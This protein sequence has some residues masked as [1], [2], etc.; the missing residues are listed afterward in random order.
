[1]NDFDKTEG[2]QSCRAMREENRALRLRLEELE[3][4]DA[5]RASMDEAYHALV[6]HSLQGLV[7]FQDGRAVFANQAMAA[8][9]GY[10]VDEILAMSPEAIREFVHP[11]DRE[12]VW[13]RSRKRLAG[14][15]APERYEMRGVRKDGGICWLEIHAS[16]IHFRDRPAI[17]AAYVDITERKRGGQRMETLAHAALGLVGMPT[18]ADVF[19]F[20]AEKVLALIGEGIVSVHS[21]EGNTLT[22]RKVMGAKGHVLK[23]A[24]RLL[25]GHVIGLPID[26][27]HEEARTKL[28][29]GRLNKVEGGL[30]E[31]FFHTVPQTVC[32][33]LERAIGGTGQYSVGLRQ[34]GRL[35]GNVT[36]L[37]Q[38]GTEVDDW[39]IEV[40]V[41]QASIVLER[42]EA[43]EA[44]RRSEVRLTRVI[45]GTDDATWEWPDLSKEETWWSPR[46]FELLGYRPNAF[47]PTTSRF[48]EMMHPDDRVLHAARMRS[49][50]ESDKPFEGEYRLRH[51][52]GTYHWFHA[53]GR[54]FRDETGRPICMSGSVRDVSREKL[55]ERELESAHHFLQTVLNSFPGNVVVLD[56]QGVIV[57]ANSS[58]VSFGQANGLACK[59]LEEGVNYLE[60]TRSAK[61]QWSEGAREVCEAIEAI[62]R[63]EQT[64][65]HREYPCHS[66][67]KQRWFDMQTR[68]FS[69]AGRRW[70]VVAHIDV[71]ERKES[72]LNRELSLSVL[73]ILNRA[74]NRTEIVRDILKL[75]KAHHGFTAVAIRLC[76]GDDYPYFVQNGF[77]DDFVR[78][79][80]PLCA[81][82][83][84]GDLVR[85]DQGRPLLECM[86]GNVIQGRVDPSQSFFTKGGSFW[87]NGTTELL[88]T[89]R[90][91]DRQAR[92]RN[93][94]N[95]EGYE[96]V[97]LIPLRSGDQVIGLLQMNDLRPGRFTEERVRFFEGVG[98]SIGIAISRR[99][100]DEALRA[101]EE[102]Y[103][104]LV[105]N[106]NDVIFTVNVEGIITYLSPPMR[107]LTGYAPKELV[108]RPFREIVHSE[109][110]PGLDRSFRDVLANRLELSEFRYHAKDGSLRWA[111]TSSRPILRN[112][113]AMGIRGALID[114][115]ERKLME[116]TLAERNRLLVEINALSIELASL[117]VEADVQA[118]AAEYLMRMAGVAAAWF[119]EY[120]PDRK[121][122][123]V[124]HVK[125]ESGLL[126]KAAQLLGR[127]PEGIPSPVSDEMYSE[128]I[129]APVGRRKTL[130]EMSF[131]SIPRLVGSAVQALLGA[132]RF[133]GLAHVIEGKLFGTS[134]LAMKADRPDPPT[135]LLESIAH[136]VAV[137]LRRSLAEEELMR[138]T[139]IF[140]SVLH[141]IS[142][143]VYILDSSMRF[144]YVSQSAAKALGRPR[145]EIVD[146]C[147]RDLDM[148]NDIMLPFERQVH[149][150]LSTGK[151]HRGEVCYPTAQGP[152]QMEY[153]VSPV[154][155]GAGN[156]PL[157][158]N[159]VRDITERRQAE[160]ALIESEI[161]FRGL[162]DNM[163]CGCAIYEAVDEGAD[164]V[165]RD[166]NKAGEEIEHIE[167]SR[168]IGRRLT[169][170]FPG[171]AETGFLDALRVAW[172]TRGAIHH[173]PMFYRD[174]RV[175]HW[176][177]NRLYTL[178]SGEVVA[179][180]DDITERKEIET[181][182]LDYQRRLRSLAAELVRT[183]T[184]ERRRI[185]LGLH[186]NV[187]QG[188][189]MM[190]LSLQTL[191][192]TVD[193]KAASALAR[194]C[195]DIDGLMD[196]IR[197]LSFELSDNILYEVGLCEAVEAHLEQTIRSKCGL[198]YDLQT[199]GDCSTLD[200]DMKA[201]LFRSFR[202]LAA[203][204]IKHAQAKN[205]YV[206]LER[207]G[208]MIVLEVRDD[209][210]GSS[211]VLS[212]EENPGHFGLF[213]IR[214]QIGALGGKLEIHTESGHG[215]CITIT[216]PVQYHVRL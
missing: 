84:E 102:K 115:T 142:D 208:D 105:E 216:A 74:E 28:L 211:G 165:F 24:E 39:A 77:P 55:A 197:S 62:F 184:R 96:S 137:S 153:I 147:W 146:K 200:T 3:G 57:V 161:R 143:H 186:D 151:H 42:R 53:R 206:R 191:C 118:F 43:E 69:H 145:E 209:G 2:P 82:T 100:S 139:R 108:G 80:S 175:S 150:A 75:V 116:E 47:T 174:Q 48:F 34:S 70:V 59:F 35:F 180:Y 172:R 132:N 126:G 15:P 119:C 159:V 202:E 1:M 9:T 205:M 26:G 33:A 87:T 45:E 187:A 122:L 156:A 168:V 46:F 17:Q 104:N 154:E 79:E 72:E 207:S 32:K 152:R 177:E 64:D 18:G 44:L 37:A 11:E 157:V 204:V 90:E 83:P 16:Q 41:N 8:I 36:I 109:D 103:R 88:A 163:T 50:V 73:A 94:C 61:G 68:G 120:V 149:A 19:V 14:E 85:D 49:L 141:S 198:A 210:R 23:L 56:E 129:A 189:A 93:R 128:I 199:S 123:V 135:E 215:T 192:M 171:V 136:L 167:K 111:R 148:P 40:L 60:V 212:M 92:T 158:L 106:I 99:G 38:E 97:A 201:V 155:L 52:S 162:F 124:R 5:Q 13:E 181:R 54:V 178:S 195:S 4:R 112:D 113:T 29:T 101:S 25:G 176:V 125:A 131:G 170:V 169:E 183:E 117:P 134:G 213:S 188:L 98:A 138:H 12:A 121:A 107:R 7:I 127:R 67:D 130:T 21:I 20:V 95:R 86:C 114:I 71:T 6:D 144:L 185:G 160:R 30:Y 190:K 81:R 27:L 214:E 166:F 179:I 51:K 194:S 89:T 58:W 173:P 65:F 193:E 31:L 164:F 78:K 63:G 66:P 10:R 182:L 203:N 22:I 196:E 140:D 133:I 110:L 76:E 91:T